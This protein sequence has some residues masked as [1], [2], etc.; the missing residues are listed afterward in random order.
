M[1]MTKNEFL[2]LANE[3]LNNFY[4]LG[5]DYNFKVSSIKLEVS[6][7]KK[8]N[9]PTWFVEFEERN[10]IRFDKVEKRLDGIEQR[11]SAVEQ[12]IDDIEVKLERNNI[13]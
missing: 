5:K 3:Y 1:Q 11:L 2:K 4:K 10:N 6:E 7:M 13:K 12:R 8:S 9:A